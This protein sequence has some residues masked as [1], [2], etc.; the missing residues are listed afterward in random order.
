MIPFAASVFTRVHNLGKLIVDQACYAQWL[1][2][3]Q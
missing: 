2:S 3:G 1:L